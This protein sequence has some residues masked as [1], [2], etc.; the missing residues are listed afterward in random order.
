MPVGENDYHAF[1]F[2]GNGYLSSSAINSDSEMI[3][4]SP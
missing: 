3:S 4:Q 2:N 1:F